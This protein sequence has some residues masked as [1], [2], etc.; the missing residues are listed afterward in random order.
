MAKRKKAKRKQNPLLLRVNPP[1]DLKSDEVENLWL[2]AQRLARKAGISLTRK[3]FNASV[4]DFWRQHHALP[5]K[6]TLQKT[7]PGIDERKV[8]IVS[9]IGVME[10][11]YYTPRRNSRKQPYKYVHKA[12][13]TFL[14]SDT[15]GN[16][17]MLGETIMKKDGWLHK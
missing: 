2:D 4:K 12:P 15:E 3:E 9:H 13:Q 11:I 8:K 1:L 16:V 17:Y 14:V 5:D 7:P 6:I 10:N